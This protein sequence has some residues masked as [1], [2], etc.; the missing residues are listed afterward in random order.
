MNY[1]NC[2]PAPLLNLN[3]RWIA[4]RI[5]Y[6]NFEQ[7]MQ[8]LYHHQLYGSLNTG[9][10]IKTHIRNFHWKRVDV[11]QHKL[12][13]ESMRLNAVGWKMRNKATQSMCSA[14]CSV[15]VH[16]SNTWIAFLMLRILFMAQRLHTFWSMTL[17]C[18]GWCFNR[19]WYVKA[20]G[21]SIKLM[22]TRKPHFLIFEF[23]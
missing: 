12:L 7:K 18:I 23:H 2:K 10:Q 3:I 20:F 15:Q 13:D 16:R 1:Y 8:F 22:K 21:F 9:H 11:E 5:S 6:E 4:Y 19:L 17:Q 14:L